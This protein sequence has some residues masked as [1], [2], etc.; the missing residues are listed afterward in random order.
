MSQENVEIV[1]RAFEYEVHGRGDPSEAEADFDPDVVMKPCDELPT[2]GRESIRDN[3]IRWSGAW[4]DLEVTAEEYVDAGDQV[5]VVA[6]HRAQ[7]RASGISI[8]ALFYSVYTLRDAKIVRVEEFVDRGEA[9]KAA[10]VSE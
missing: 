5:V 8:D 10:G 6:R 4:E 7:G 2:S 3:M 9:L 1:G